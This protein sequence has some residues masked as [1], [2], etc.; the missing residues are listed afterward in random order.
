MC[1]PPGRLNLLIDQALQLQRQN[2][3]FHNKDDNEG[4]LSDHQCQKSNFPNTATHIFDEHQDEVWF[5]EFSKNGTLLASA[6]RDA[7]AIIWDVV[8]FKI[9]FILD[10]HKKAISYLAWSPCDQFLLTAS[11]DFTLKLW[12][13]KVF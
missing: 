1:I 12:D 5:M 3:I 2:C 8:D 11:N 9:K 10:K 7:R 6:S 13:A 4:L